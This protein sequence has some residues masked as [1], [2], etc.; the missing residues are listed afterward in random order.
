MTYRSMRTSDPIH[1]HTDK[2]RQLVTIN[3]FNERNI[4]LNGK[5]VSVNYD[6]DQV[7]HYNRQ[8]IKILE[9]IGS[10]VGHQG[11]TLQPLSQDQL[12]EYLE[13]LCQEG[14]QIYQ[15]LN[16]DVGKVISR[17]EADIQPKGLRLDFS[18]PPTMACLWDMIYPIDRNGPL[19]P[20]QFWGFRYPIG[21]IPID[22]KLPEIYDTVWLRNGIFAL[23]H[24]RLTH[25]KKELEQ[26]EDRLSTLCIWL[27]NQVFLKRVEDVVSCDNLSKKAVLEYLQS[28]ECTYGIVHFAG[29]CISHPKTSLCFTAH[30]REVVI[31]AA[32]FNVLPW[33]RP[34]RRDCPMVFV[35]ACESATPSLQDQIANL[36]QSLL[37]FGAGGVIATVCT[38]PDNFA[39]AFANEFYGRLL[40][41][42][43]VN[44]RINIGE[45]LL[46][47]RQHFL[48]H[49][50]NPLGLAYGLYALSNQELKVG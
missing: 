12:N 35:N 26:L 29:H 37:N 9:Q 48:E 4:L 14:K 34:G 18:F 27:N 44:L 11:S 45:V 47:T 42:P 5:P 36:P 25:S 46:E 7:R 1:I 33:K 16:I 23:C 30:Q 40:D 32:E 20:N 24:D 8:V 49:F 15:Y 31:E 39:S 17:I 28:P 50:N 3:M 19:D 2:K 6:K 38:I 10:D 21:H 13:L 41:K 22:V 43:P